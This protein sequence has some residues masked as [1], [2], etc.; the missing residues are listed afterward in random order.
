MLGSKINKAQETHYSEDQS[1]VL[2]DRFTE[3]LFKLKQDLQEIKELEVIE[4]LE[5][6]GTGKDQESE[7]EDKQ[8]SFVTR[9]F[10]ELEELKTIFSSSLVCVEDVTW[11]LRSAIFELM[12]CEPESFTI[13][14]LELYKCLLEQAE[15]P[16][17]KIYHEHLQALLDKKTD[18]KSNFPFVDFFPVLSAAR[19]RNAGEVFSEQ[20]V[21]I[22]RSKLS[23]RVLSPSPLALQDNRLSAKVGADQ[24]ERLTIQFLS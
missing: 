9:H 17:K 2:K 14:L 1:I 6:E 23:K 11:F 22:K 21:P 20:D 12:S 8:A 4:K 10:N 16:S 24:D 5:V 7:N 13:D 3:L 19:K 15:L 18:E